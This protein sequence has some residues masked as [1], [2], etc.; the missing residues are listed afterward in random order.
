MLVVPDVLSREDC[1]VVGWSHRPRGTGFHDVPQGMKILVSGY[2]VSGQEILT[3][4]SDGAKLDLA[5]SYTHQVD[6]DVPYATFDKTALANHDWRV[7]VVNPGLAQPCNQNTHFE[8]GMVTLAAAQTATPAFV[9]RWVPTKN[10]TGLLAQSDETG[11]ICLRWKSQA[12]VSVNGPYFSARFPPVQGEETLQVAGACTATPTGGT[13]CGPDSPPTHQFLPPTVKI[14]GDLG[15]EG[16][17]TN[18]VGP[19]ARDL[20]LTQG[21]TAAFNFQSDPHPTTSTATSWEWQGPAVQVIQPS[22]VNT[23]DTQRENN[24]VFLSGIVLGLAGAALIALIQELIALT[25]SSRAE[26]R[27]PA[28]ARDA[29]IA[30]PHFRSR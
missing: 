15:I 22:A 1:V 2:D 26:N 17:G 3:S 29:Q 9:V 6:S 8:R 30:Q 4:T 10:N 25:T 23:S 5:F 7:I 19:F 24:R 13:T 28:N 14:P 11:D 21:S 27:A 16:Q 12:P 18:L 20:K